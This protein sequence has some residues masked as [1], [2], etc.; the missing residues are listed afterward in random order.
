[1]SDG[2]PSIPQG[3]VVV[4]HPTRVAEADQVAA[5]QGVKRVDLS[6]FVP[7]TH[8]YILDLDELTKL[9]E[10]GSFLA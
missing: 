10:S 1:M 9:P 8:V 2:R 4:A 3:K 7:T 5:D 6:K